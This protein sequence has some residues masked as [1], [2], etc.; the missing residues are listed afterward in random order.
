VL[1][2]ADVPEQAA[3]PTAKV[4]SA[5]AE[6]T[7]LETPSSEA[8]VTVRGSAHASIAGQVVAVPAILYLPVA[9]LPV[10]C[11]LLAAVQVTTVGAA[12]SVTGS[13]NVQ[14]SL[15][16]QYPLLHVAATE[17]LAD[18][19]V[20]VA[21]LVT[22][23]H[24]VQA[25]LFFQDPLLHV[26]ATELPEAVH[27]TVAA[28]VTASHVPEQAALPTA[29]FPPA[30]AE[31]TLL[32]TPSTAAVVS[33]RELSHSSIAGQVV[34]VPASLY[35]VEAQF[36]VSCEF[37]AAVQVTTVEAKPPVTGSHNVQ[38][39][40]F[41]QDPLLHVATT[42]L[43]EAVHVTVAALVTSSHVPEQAALPT[44]K[45]PPAHA[46][47]TLLE[48]PSTAAVVSLR[49]LSHSSI[50]GQ[51]VA[52]PA[53]L[54]LVEAQFPVSCEF[55][56]AVQVTTVEAKPP[57]TGSQSAQKPSLVVVAGLRYLPVGHVVVVTLAHAYAFVPVFHV[58]PRTQFLQKPSL[59]VVASV[60]PL[61]QV[62]EV[63]V[64]V[65][66]A[67]AFVPVFH[68]DPRTQSVQKPSLVVVASVSPLP[69][70][71]VAVVTV[72]HAF[73]F[74]PVFHVDP[75]T[76]AVQKPSLVVVVGVR[77][78]PVG[79]DLVVTVAH[80]FPFV[81]VF[82]VDPA[83]QFTQIPFAEAVAGLSPLPVV[84][85]VVVTAAHAF[86][87]VPV[88]HVDPRTQSVQKPSLVVVAGVSPLPVGHE[89]AS[90]AGQVVAVPASLY[91][92]V[93]QFP[94]SCEFPAAV[95]VT[96]VGAAP[97]VTGS[98]NVQASLFFQDPLL[99]VAATESLADPWIL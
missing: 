93:A 69:V 88:F 83:T 38:A 68:V 27:V 12:P 2:A 59:V 52:V 5:H 84:Q 18:E 28:L 3:L 80:A 81:P 79:H 54:Y 25:S 33:L 40:L 19:H 60:S 48:T 77:P 73:A 75:R 41:F 22:T 99:H 24:A 47:Q 89:V 29:N 13:H 37:P 49:E 6:Q 90:I 51:V 1:H 92:P 30:H 82:H 16:F 43:P 66:H 67:F 55:P 35:L 15:F 72:K 76:Q 34:A 71:H 62:H 86:A 78:L 14:A 63:V 20:T 42:E 31:Q 70:V 97:S 32:E 95:Q 36:P 44:A 23:S 8:V 11:E 91:L 53:S 57:V 26:A 58:D 9:Q 96:T 10:S 39:S 74:V 45:V 98:H 87:F 7:L 17:S 21:A 65:A 56:A 46:A 61:P 4:P 94:V 85:T 64:T 50:A